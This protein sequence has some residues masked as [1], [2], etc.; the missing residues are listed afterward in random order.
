[1]NSIQV[2]E[3]LIYF[4]LHSDRV[5]LVSAKH[6][7]MAIIQSINQSA[8][9]RGVRAQ[10]ICQLLVCLRMGRGDWLMYHPHEPSLSRSI[11]IGLQR[12]SVLSPLVRY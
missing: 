11:Y 8:H 5:K 10:P 9:P 4:S 6:E 12:G 3:I 7:K 2:Q 1:M